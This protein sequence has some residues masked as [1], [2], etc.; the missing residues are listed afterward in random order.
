MKFYALFPAMMQVLDQPAKLK[1]VVE[2]QGFGHMSID[3][4]VPRVVVF[5]DALLD[6]LQVELGEQFS[7][8]AQQGWKAALNYFGGALVYTKANFAERL[9][10]LDVSWKL[11]T[12]G[13]GKSKDDVNAAGKGAMD[14]KGKKGD[15]LKKKGCDGCQG[16]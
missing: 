7:R 1:E 8:R 6:L 2:A 12:A 11:A 15:K 13:D 4:T 3:V 16:E 5:R 10:L 14:A 9:G